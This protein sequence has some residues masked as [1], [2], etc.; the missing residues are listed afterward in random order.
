MIVH[1]IFLWARAIRNPVM[2]LYYYSLERISRWIQHVLT[3]N[4][5]ANVRYKHKSLTFTMNASWISPIVSQNNR[6]EIQI[7]R[8]IRIWPGS[9]MLSTIYFYFI[10]ALDKMWCWWKR[11]YELNTPSQTSFVVE[12]IFLLKEKEKVVCFVKRKVAFFSYICFL[13]NKL[14]LT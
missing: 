4:R 9:C 14:Y 7:S 2:A 3:Q 11:E 12:D 13:Y 8:Y 10:G 5:A 1:G 6:D